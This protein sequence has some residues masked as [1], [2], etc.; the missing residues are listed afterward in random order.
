YK[1]LDLN[2]NS[3]IE[4]DEIENATAS[5]LVLDKNKNGEVSEQEL[6]GP[7]SF[8][9]WVRLQT[10]VRVI[11]YDGDMNLSSD[12]LSVATDR[13]KRLDHN[14][15]G[16]LKFDELID[17]RI[18]T[19]PSGANV[20]GNNQQQA[21]QAAGQRNN[22]G[23]GPSPQAR[24]MIAERR[25]FNALPGGIIEGMLEAILNNSEVTEPILPGDDERAWQGYTLFS[26][27]NIA[28]DI[29]IA[30]KTY[31]LNPKGEIAHTW[32]NERPGVPE[33]AAVYLLENGLL[34]RQS[35]PDDWVTMEHHE[36][37]ANGVLELVDWGGT[38]LWSYQ[39]CETDKHCLHHDVEPLPNGNILAL[40]YEAF[41]AQD[42]KEMGW[43]SSATR[44]NMNA[45][46]GS[47]QAREPK[48][49]WME[50]ILEL[51]PNLESGSTDIVWEWNSWDHLVQEVDEEKPNFGVVKKQS[52][53]IDINFRP[54]QDRQ[55]HVNSIDYNPQTNQILI[56]TMMFGEIWIIER[57][58]NSAISAS[59]Q[60][61]K[62]GKGGDILYRWGNPAAYDSA[63]DSERRITGQHDARWLLDLPSIGGGGI[64]VHNNV[65]GAVDGVIGRT[66]FRL[67]S[68]YSEVLELD[69]KMQS[70]GFYKKQAGQP[71]AGELSWVYSADPKNS[72]YAPFMSG[73]NRLPNGNTLVI[74]S[75]NKRIFEVM[76][77]G[78][79]VLDYQYPG[80]GR[81]FRVYKLPAAYPGIS[82]LFEN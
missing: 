11:D 13:L 12:E 15:D 27:S 9:G 3:I 78:T 35:A 61:G 17:A 21:G 25:A 56:S 22:Q 81:M 45:G 41:S 72:W 19:I 58:E 10:T 16:V 60:G 26:E 38:V 75:H 36:V 82:K 20:A 55:L 1:A 51:K 59:D 49:I 18:A 76:P 77:D 74:N 53:K 42:V 43:D 24:A 23:A 7:G 68:R 48:T 67:G 62:Y 44:S 39:R 34:L 5:L 63:P 4:G 31:L 54:M 47:N 65:G 52:G 29:Q 57:G 80:T 37:G 69:T 79:L 70:D 32:H 46:Q 2:G 66:M 73:A 8:S 14:H 64:L 30:S 28:A 50:K 40:S 33:G 71:H 6:G